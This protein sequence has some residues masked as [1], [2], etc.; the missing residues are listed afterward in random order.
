ILQLHAGDIVEIFAQS[1]I[2]GVISSTED[3][4]HFEAARFPS[5]IV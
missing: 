1:S 3:G 2:D 5:P 4:S